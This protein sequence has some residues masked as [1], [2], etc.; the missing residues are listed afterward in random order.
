MATEEEIKS[1]N[2][3]SDDDRIFYHALYHLVAYW[4]AFMGTIGLLITSA[5][6]VSTGPQ[7]PEGTRRWVFLGTVSATL[8]TS[9]FLLW[10]QA[11]FASFVKDRLLRNYTDD[12]QF[13]WRCFRPSPLFNW[14]AF[15]FVLVIAF[16]IFL[17]VLCG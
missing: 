2:E 5:L 13:G 3:Q 14:I 9:V 12:E 10:R 15:L 6:V 16:L 11:T 8:V 17:D 1:S 7:S 4:A